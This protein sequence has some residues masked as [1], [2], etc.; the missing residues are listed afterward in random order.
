MGKAPRTQS[1]KTPFSF[2]STSLVGKSLAFCMIFINFWSGFHD[3]F[4]RSSLCRIAFKIAVDYIFV[5]FSSPFFLLWLSDASLFLWSLLTFAEYQQLPPPLAAIKGASADHNTQIS[6][7]RLTLIWIRICHFSWVV[8]CGYTRRRDW[9]LSMLLSEMSP[10]FLQGEK[11]LQ[12]PT[13]RKERKS[14]DDIYAFKK[15]RF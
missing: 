7:L 8:Y 1:Q 11:T 4:P 9:L 15:C 13:K 12:R 14:N 3:L 10:A 2:K 5:V 6:H